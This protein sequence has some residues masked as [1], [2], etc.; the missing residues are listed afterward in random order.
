MISLSGIKELSR[1]DKTGQ[2]VILGKK[3]GVV[4][5]LRKDI[6]YLVD[7]QC[8]PH[9]LELAPLEVQKS[10]KSVKEV[11]D[12]INLVWMTYHY[13][14]NNSRKLK[15]LASELSVDALKPAQVSGTQWL[16]HVSCALKVFIKSGDAKTS[17]EPTGQYALV[18]CHMEHLST[19]STST[20]IK[21]HPKFIAKRIRDVQF[22]AF[23][24][25]LADM[26]SILGKHSLKMQSDDLILPIAV[27]QLKERVTS[28]TSLKS[29]HVPNGYLEKFLKVSNKSSNKGV[30]VFQGIELK[31]SLKEKVEHIGSGPSFNSEVNKA[32]NLC[33]Y[34][35]K[36]C[37]GQLMDSPD[38]TD[39]H[40]PYGPNN[41]I[42]DFLIFTGASRRLEPVLKCCLFLS[43][44]QCLVSRAPLS[45]VTKSLS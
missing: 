19:S 42:Q 40:S 37:F 8:L 15:S 6:P 32:I 11:Y 27:F 35:L 45:A 44:F 33:L 38:S 3:G 23:C 12:M 26:F 36:E 9:R 41:V 13:N 10:C 20:D 1:L 4:A 29:R 34:G 7:F 24:H 43:F 25:F 21:G 2:V 16:P 17:E 22:S 31:G 28:I 18:L 30:K 14:A 5:L 39:S